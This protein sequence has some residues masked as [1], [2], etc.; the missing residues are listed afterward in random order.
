MATKTVYI[1]AC[2]SSYRKEFQYSIQGYE[3]SADGGY[4]LLE[5]REIEFESPNDT[6]LRLRIAE[7]LRGKKNKILAEAHIEAKE[8]DETIQELLAL[9]DKSQPSAHDEGTQE[10]LAGITAGG[11]DDIPF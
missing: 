11:D 7:A 8:V 2:W 10:G 5:A 6:T 4:I 9:E 1:V 3:P